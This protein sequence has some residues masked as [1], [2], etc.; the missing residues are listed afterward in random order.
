MPSAPVRAVGTGLLFVFAS[1]S[2]TV[3][4]ATGNWRLLWV[5]LHVQFMIFSFPYSSVPDDPCRLDI[6]VLAKSR[7]RSPR[8]PAMYSKEP[9]ATGVF[10]SLH[11]L[12]PA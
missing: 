9:S 11:S 6:L 7:W 3:A 10:Q 5:T 1:K 4:W 2:A 12:L 8:Q